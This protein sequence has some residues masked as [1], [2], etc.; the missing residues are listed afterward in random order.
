[1]ATGDTNT[2]GYYKIEACCTFINAA[3]EKEIYLNFVQLTP[4]VS[5]LCF[6]IGSSGV[7]DAATTYN[8][9]SISDMLLL[10]AGLTYNFSFSSQTGTTSDLY[11]SSKALITR[12]T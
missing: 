8:N 2:T 10:T 3:A 5:T 7:E 12:V 1:M 9:V 11:S 6:S 4:S